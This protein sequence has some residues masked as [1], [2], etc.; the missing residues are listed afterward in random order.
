VEQSLLQHT[1][2]SDSESPQLPDQLVEAW[3]N[4]AFHVKLELP[5]IVSY[6][7]LFRLGVWQLWEKCDGNLC[8]LT[9]NWA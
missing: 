4:P 3:T 5:N 7:R 2:L 1:L 8:Y 9:A 6:S